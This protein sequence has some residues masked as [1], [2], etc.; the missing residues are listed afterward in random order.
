MGKSWKEKPWKYK[1]N[2]DFQKKHKKHKE[3]KPFE[4]LPDSGD[5]TTLIEEIADDVFNEPTE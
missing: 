5:D 3:Q 4:P 2:K 1:N